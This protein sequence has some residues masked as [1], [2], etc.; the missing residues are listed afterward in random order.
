MAQTTAPPA[1]AN[2]QQVPELSIGILYP[3]NRVDKM[4]QPLRETRFDVAIDPSDAY[5]RDVVILDNADRDLAKEVLKQPFHDA[6]VLYRMRGDLFHELELWEMHPIKNYAAHKVVEFV[7][8]CL[9]VTERLADKFTA[10][11][12]VQ[13][14]YAGLAKDVEQWPETTHSSTELRLTTLTN[15]GYQ[16]K[17]QALVDYAPYVNNVL[18][19]HGGT[20]HLCGDGRHSDWVAEQVGQYDHIEWCGYVDAR[21]ELQWAN[22]MLHLSYL[23]GQPNSILEGMAAELPVV[24]NEFTAFTEFDGPIQIVGGPREMEQTLQRLRSPQT[25]AY[26]GRTNRQY[27]DT[28]HSFDAIARRYEQAITDLV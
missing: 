14:T 17:V 24:C 11:T 23:D 3:G 28:E 20:W 27:I 26:Q 4:A 15:A 18:S 19:E 7:D 21:E 10:K 22:G 9:A 12:G 5:S 16:K 8:G 6:T 1:E 13:S 2:T 25:R